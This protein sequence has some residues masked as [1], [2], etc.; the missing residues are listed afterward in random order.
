MV[1]GVRIDRTAPSVSFSS[2]QAGATVWGDSVPVTVEASDELAGLDEVSINGQPASSNGDGSFSRSVPLTCGDN[3]LTAAGRD[4][5][6][7][8]KTITRKVTRRCMAISSA[9]APIATSNGSQ[10]SVSATNLNAFKVKSV[11]PV[12]FRAYHDEAQTELMTSPPAGS[13]AKLGLQRYDASTGTTDVP[14]YVSAGS[15]NTDGLFRWSSTDNQYVYNLGTA[16]RAAGTYGVQ[17]TLY[18]ADGTVLG[19]SALQWFVLKV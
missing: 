19:R 6:G 7:N 18:G 15:A 16:G 8:G 13:Y 12:K 3:S 11:I 1:S 5:A 17:L 2:P 10:T 14:D 9:L 4:K